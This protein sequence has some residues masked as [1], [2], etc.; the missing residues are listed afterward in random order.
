[1][2]IFMRRAIKN[3]SKFIKAYELGK[4]YAEIQRLINEGKIKKISEE[5]Y[6]IFSQ[7]AVNGKGQI[8][9]KGD[10]IKIDTTD[11]PYPNDRTFFLANHKYLQND[12]YK[13][14]SHPVYIWQAYEDICLEV[15]FLIKNK[16]LVIDR[17]SNEK[18]YT[19]PLWGTVLSAARDA[20]LIFYSIKKDSNGSIVDIDFNFIECKEFEKTYTIFD[21]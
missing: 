21:D 10:F 18:Y 15:E 6:E 5:V 14:I 7:E 11:L 13:Q 16:H 19:V 2:V 4:E 3:E 8:A 20:Y 1:M 9:H 12:E 17:E